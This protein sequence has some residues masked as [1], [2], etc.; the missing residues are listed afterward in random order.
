MKNLFVL[1][2]A[3]VVML[4]VACK[5]VDQE[6]IGK[7]QADLSTMESMGPSFEKLGTGI[8]NL[9]NQLNAVPESMKTET[10]PEYQN[11]LRLSNTM[12]QKYQATLAEQGDLTGKIKNLVADY[13]SGKITTED[14]VKEY[15]TLSTSVKGISEVMDRMSQKVDQIQAEFAKMSATLNAKAEEAAQK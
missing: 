15:E 2:V 12:T 13:T 14:A 5:G 3:A 8:T 1:S 7:L 11:M 6:L 10:N 4:A 9:S